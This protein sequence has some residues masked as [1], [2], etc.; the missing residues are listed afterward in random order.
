MNAKNLSILI[1]TLALITLSSCSSIKEDKPIIEETIEEQEYY[2]NTRTIDDNEQVNTDLDT[3]NENLGSYD[4]TH[5]PASRTP[6]YIQNKSQ[7]SSQ[8]SNSNENTILYTEE[9]VQEIVDT[10]T[11][12]YQKI[13]DENTNYYQDVVN[14]VSNDYETALIEYENYITA[15]ENDYTTVEKEYVTLLTELGLISSEESSTENT[16]KIIEEPTVIVTE[17]EENIDDIY[18]KI[19]EQLGGEEPNPF[20]NSSSKEP[21]SNSNEENN[22]EKGKITLNDNGIISDRSKPKLNPNP[23]TSDDIIIIP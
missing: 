21:N 22:T 5:G 19:I 3:S 20:D 18:N 11:N 7:P 23:L 2:F 17:S 10:L 9:E 13:V 1:S 6:L 12:D 8:A 4:Y 15:L 14:S 16:E